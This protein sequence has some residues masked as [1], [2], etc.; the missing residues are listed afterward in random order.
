MGLIDSGDILEISIL[1][2]FQEQF[3]FFF[4]KLSKSYIAGILIMYIINAV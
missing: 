4:N 2:S 1:H 3:D